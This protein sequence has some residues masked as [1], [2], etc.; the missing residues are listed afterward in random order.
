[1]A[2]AVPGADERKCIEIKTGK[3]ACLRVS[4]VR[5]RESVAGGAEARGVRQ[6]QPASGQAFARGR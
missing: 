2:T 1:M 5:L 3:A 4:V 6:S